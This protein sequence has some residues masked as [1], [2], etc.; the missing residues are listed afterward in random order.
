MSENNRYTLITGGTEG[1]GLELSRLFAK[2]KHNLII[3]ARNK[4]RLEKVKKEVEKE[5]NIVARILSIDL[6]VNNSCEEIYRFVEKNNFV[7]DNLINNAGIGSFG[8]F[9]ELDMEKEEKLI[10]INIRSLTKLTNYFLKKMIDEKT[11][12]ILNV[13]STAAFLAGP[14]MNIYYAS[15]AYVLSLT[16]A[17]HEEVK[18]YGIRVSCLCPGAVQ[19]AFQNKAGI[20]KNDKTK[21]LMMSPK[22]VAR[23]AYRD[24]KKGKVII[25]PGFKNK[26][27]VL[28]NKLASRSLGRKIVMH[29][30]KSK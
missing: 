9:H 23:I 20:M 5:F 27:L 14:K 17:I 13:A 18:D 6:S 30:N 22:E 21:G 29:S 7:V 10:E 12:G 8:S 25:I 15:K 19:T 16:E 11:G 3:V 1:I 26:L 2:D 28:G 24:F 4:E